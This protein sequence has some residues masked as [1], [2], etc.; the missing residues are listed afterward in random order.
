MWLVD[1]PLPDSNDAVEDA[2]YVEAGALQ[3]TGGDQAYVLPA[4]FDPDDYRAVVV[5]CRMLAEKRD[6]PFT[7]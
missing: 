7:P 4:D 6:G 5:W 2:A 1:D 3:G